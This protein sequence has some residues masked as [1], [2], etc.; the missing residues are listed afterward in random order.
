MVQA[1]PRHQIRTI[2][3]RPPGL[4]AGPSN[5]FDTSQHHSYFLP[6]DRYQLRSFT[7]QSIKWLAAQHPH[8]SFVSDHSYP[9]LNATAQHC[10]TTCHLILDLAT[11]KTEHL[12]LCFRFRHRLRTGNIIFEPCILNLVRQWPHRRSRKPSCFPMKL[13]KVCLKM[14]RSHFS[15]LTIVSIATLSLNPLSLPLH[16]FTAPYFRMRR[17]HDWRAPANHHVQ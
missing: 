11:P 16:C 10:L 9:A 15:K 2:V 14:P 17:I 5:Q 8:R 4:R 3:G 1:G 6:H 7:V 12:I 13:S